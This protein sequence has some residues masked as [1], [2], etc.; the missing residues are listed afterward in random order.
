M[1]AIATAPKSAVSMP[2]T[3][4]ESTV[5]DATAELLVWLDSLTASA[6]TT[7]ALFWTEAPIGAL[8]VVTI[9][10]VELSPALSVPSL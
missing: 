8:T 1:L 5:M 9:D 7:D 2:V 3:G 10:T 4:R 6:A